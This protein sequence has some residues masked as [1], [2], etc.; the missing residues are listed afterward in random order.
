M[1]ESEF[2]KELRQMVVRRASAMHLVDTLAFVTEV[3]ERLEEDPVFGE[4]VLAEY[5]AQDPRKRQL[6]I[7]G[8]TEIGES[9]GAISLVIGRWADDA[10]PGP[11]LTSDVA[12]MRGWLENFTAAAVSGKLDER[13]TPSSQAY[14]LAN[15]LRNMKSDISCIRLHIFSNQSLSQRYK[16]E[17][18]S[19][20]ADIPTETHIWD[21]QRLMALYGSGRER[22]MVEI[23]LSDFTPKGI[24]CIEASRTEG[25]HSY[26]CVIEGNVL[27]D[28]FERYG[29]R[30]L[31]GNVR[32][33]LGMKG[34]VNKG[35]RTTIQDTPPLFFAYNNGIAATAIA[36]RIDSSGGMT[37]I[38]EISDLQIV[39]GGQTTASVLR[40]RKQDRLSLD[41]VTVPMKLTVV[42]RQQAHDLI[43][44]IAEYANTQNKVAIADFFANHPLH[45]KIE[46]ISRRLLVPAK[47]GAR[48]QSKWFYE[49]S[50]GQ[51][52]NE[53]LYL[54]KARKDAFDLEYPAKQVVNKT[55]LAKY[56]S[57]LGEKPYWAS[58][59]A[60]KNFMKF[61]NQF[62]PKGGKTEAEHWQEMSASFG[63]TYYQRIVGMAIL[64]QAGEEAVAAGKGTWYMGDYRPQIVA[65]AWS[66][67]L[68][69]VR[70]EGLEIDLARVWEKQG[71][72][73]EL[74]TCFVSAAKLAQKSLL[75]LPAGSTNVGE[76][77]KKEACWEK[78]ASLRLDLGD[79]VDH[80]TSTRDEARQKRTE[81]R[82]QGSQDDGISL[83]N[84][85]V[86]LTNSGYWEA[87]CEW[88][89]VDQIVHGPEK[90]V[91]QRATT[92][93]SVV[94]ITSERDWRKLLD[95]KMR[96]ESEGFRASKL[97]K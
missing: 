82:R 26:L 48:V 5:T 66:L 32:S 36:A 34:G 50:R 84:E 59:G 77:A 97:S 44:R 15:T 53:R 55:E 11:L 12:Q 25:L 87:L 92:L 47:A 80:W 4:F 79:A 91:L 39:N 70:T 19:A 27:A 24:P 40:A 67:V 33:F 69:S 95:I 35:I 94:R 58:L 86:R 3:A 14:T 56:D 6:K 63:E 64:W 23:N 43:P 45:R 89:H 46:E 17:F 9:D 54:T 52:Q 42:A 20:I 57:T 78:I 28:L 65:Y 41:G 49:R 85:I 18:R 96:C 90:A 68:H 30:L 76:W 71:I 8:F 1:D 72:D 51:Y 74:R 61:A 83:Q 73:D 88:K 29:S 22:E 31:E 37:R 13:I 38:T 7:H 75:E 2:L 21:L 60:Q 10:E 16:K 62:S 93:Q 81:S